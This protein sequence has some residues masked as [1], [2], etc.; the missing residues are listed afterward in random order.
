MCYVSVIHA[1]KKKKLCFKVGHGFIYRLAFSGNKTLP[2]TISPYLTKFLPQVSLLS[3]YFELLNEY[4]F[5]LHYATMEAGLLKR[6][7]C[8]NRLT[9]Y[10]ALYPLLSPLSCYQYLTSYSQINPTSR[11]SPT[12]GVFESSGNK[13]VLFYKGQ[14]PSLIMEI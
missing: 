11:I 6:N 14:L 3:S 8:I 9:S 4:H 12:R 1:R 10:N 2:T 13:N 5:S 7:Y